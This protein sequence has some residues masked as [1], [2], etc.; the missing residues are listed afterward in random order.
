MYCQ[1]VTLTHCN[2]VI[3]LL[4]CDFEFLDLSFELF[5]TASQKY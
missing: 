3:G 1:I 2:L 4:G 5:L